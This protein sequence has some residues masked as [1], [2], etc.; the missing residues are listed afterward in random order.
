MLRRLLFC[1]LLAAVAAPAVH[2]QSSAPCTDP[3]LCVDTTYQLSPS[4][5]GNGS[6]VLGYAYL[7]NNSVTTAF[8]NG[9]AATSINGIAWGNYTTAINSSAEGANASTYGFNANATVQDGT[10]LGSGATAQGPSSSIY[11]GT[12]QTAVGAQSGALNTLA[13]AVGYQAVANGANALALGANAL[14]NGYESIALLGNATGDYSLAAGVNSNASGQYSIA[15][16]NSSGALAPY[17]M[18]FGYAASVAQTA[19]GSIAFA[20]LNTTSGY[21]V[22]RAGVLD[23][24]GRQV[25]NIAPGTQGTDAVDLNQLNAAISGLPTGGTG[26]SSPVWIASTDTA[27]AAT[28]QGQQGTAIGAG[29]QAGNANTEFNVAL[30]TNAQ[31]G[32]TGSGAA[33]TGG[34]ATALGAG[35]QANALA[36]EAIGYQAQATASFS[37]AIGSGSLADQSNTVSFGN[38]QTGATRR[39]VNIADG[40]APTDAMTVNQGQ[41]VMSVFGAGANFETLTAPTYALTQCGAACA[42]TYYDVGSALSALDRGEGALWTAIDNLPPPTTGGGSGTDPNAV[43]YDQG[44]NNK[45]VTLQGQGGTQ[46]HNVAAGTAQTDAANV[47]QVQAAQQTAISTSETYTDSKAVEYDNASKSSVTLG[48]VDAAGNAVTPAVTLSNVADGAVDATSTQAV[49]GAQLYQTQQADRAYTDQQIAGAENWAKSYTDNKFAQAQRQ[50]DEAGAAGGVMGTLALSAARVAPVYNR[51][52]N[53]SMAA[54]G[55]DGTGAIAIGWSQTLNNGRVGVAIG[56]SFTAD[57][58]FIGGSVSIGLGD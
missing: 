47:G 18:A 42:G 48:G 24:G 45:S 5:T 4:A 25:S 11:S 3:F 7:G 23:V 52:G 40:T 6:L 28:A 37:T 39:L 33:G 13:T 1:A 9:T 58:T 34:Q 43:H 54:G 51:L 29:S 36:S 20:P 12:G 22:T 55:Y 49:N 46:I 30:G 32:V 57:H 15:L 27:T 53:L 10:A 19:T 56:A 17:S 35:A 8:A 2:A 16:G 26:G 41:E 31:A 50:A 44:S 38:D 21:T 14:S